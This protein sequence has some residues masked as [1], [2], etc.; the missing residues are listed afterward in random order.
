MLWVEA[1]SVKNYQLAHW[2]LWSELYMLHLSSGVL[3]NLRGE[4]YVMIR[5]SVGSILLNNRHAVQVQ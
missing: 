2:V 3:D 5:A 4:T 1:E